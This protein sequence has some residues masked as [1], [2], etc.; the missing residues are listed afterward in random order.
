MA[1]TDGEETS[2]LL[3]RLPDVQALAL[4]L[5]EAQLV[6][7]STRRLRFGGAGLAD[8]EVKPG[9]DLMVEVPADGRKRF[10]RRYTVRRLDR[11][12]GVVDLDIVLHGDGP[13][14]RWAAAVDPGAQVEA[15]GPRG[16]IF[17]AED[18]DW[19]LFCAD[20]ASLPATLAMIEA[21]PPDAAVIALVE[22]DGDADHVAPEGGPHGLDLRWLHRTQGAGHDPVMAETVATLPLPEG[23]GHAYVFG[24]LHQVAATR[25]ALVERGM[26]AAD[27]DHKAY[28]RLGVSNA[29]H[30]EPERP[31]TA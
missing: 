1:P 24:E 8:L 15:I 18:V 26:D 4:T 29:A 25:Q 3:Q 10:R 14:A 11:A 13:G 27:I 7:P 20:E 31:R 22:V 19:H 12:E 16:K 2:A 5:Q 9:Q 30:G 6:T 17:L 28:L 21:L 23:H